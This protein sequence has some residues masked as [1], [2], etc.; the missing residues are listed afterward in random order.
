MTTVT[1]T[2][3]DV[4]RVAAAGLHRIRVELL[5]FWRSGEAVFF[6]LGFPPIMLVL[7]GAIFGKDQIGPN[8]T[9]VTFSQYFTAG[10][11]GTGVWTSCF[12][13]LAIA[14]PLER[15]NGSLKRL[16]ATPMPL[17]AYFIG[18]IGQVTI[19]SAVE[20]LLL[21]AMG[22][23]FY[24]LHLP[25]GL[26]L[27]TFAWVFVLGC[28]ACTL[29]GLALAGLIRNGRIASSIVSPIAVILQFVSGVYFVF[30]DLPTVLQL[31]GSIFPLRWL[32]LGLRSVFLPDAYRYAEPGHSWNHPLTAIILV[33]WCAIGLLVARRTF[34]WMPERS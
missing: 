22:K 28:A 26:R 20:T 21:M 32:T 18:K 34:S 7:F 2:D 13:V 3:R 30:G 4:P 25:T 15:D 8:G 12:Q 29:T 24:G 10:M 23:L 31:A 6:T 17:S 14:V 1:S 19:I 33:A 11:I 27:V 9:S 5:Q 16:K